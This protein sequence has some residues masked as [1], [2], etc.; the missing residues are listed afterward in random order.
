MK[1]EKTNDGYYHLT[2]HAI[3]ACRFTEGDPVAVWER[4]EDV[5]R[6]TMAVLQKRTVSSVL[7]NNVERFYARFARDFQNTLAGSN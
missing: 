3:L 6:M 5:G 4:S 7:R 1:G 2:M